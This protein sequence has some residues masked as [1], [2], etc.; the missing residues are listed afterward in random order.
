MGFLLPYLE[1]TTP[2]ESLIENQAITLIIK[3]FL[4]FHQSTCASDNC[5]VHFLRTP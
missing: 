4:S 5:G 1:I 2:K 3:I